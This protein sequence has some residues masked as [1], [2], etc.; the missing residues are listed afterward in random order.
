MGG[1]SFIAKLH[2]KGNLLVFSTYLGGTGGD[3]GCA[4][5]LDNNN[6]IYVSGSTLSSDFPVKEAFQSDLGGGEWGDVFVVKVQPTGR[7]L[8]YSSY[9][10]GADSDGPNDMA[11]DKNG[12][13]HITGFTRS[14]DFP[15]KKPIYKNRAGEQDAFIVKLK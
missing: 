7:A 9:L 11:I 3:K 14:A 12:V 13:V 6:N 2:P 4:I 10:G 8:V 5:A 1:D 15:I